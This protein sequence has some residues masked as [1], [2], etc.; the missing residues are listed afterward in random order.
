M[1]RARRGIEN[2]RVTSDMNQTLKEPL[3]KIAKHAAPIPPTLPKREDRNGVTGWVLKRS[4]FHQRE[5]Q[6]QQG[7]K[8]ILPTADNQITQ[9]IQRVERPNTMKLFQKLSRSSRITRRTR[10]GFTLIEIMI[11]VLIIG[12]LLSI[13]I[14]NFISA[15]ES[16]RAKACI[17]S[18]S[19]INSA[20]IQCSLENKLAI[21]STATFSLD[22]AT[23]TTLGPNG[24]YQL[25]TYGGNSNYMRGI[26]RCPSGGV[27]SSGTV[28]TPPTCN[29]A[30]ITGSTDYQVG[31]KWYHGY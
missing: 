31:G 17:Y 19:Q 22:G 25:I 6:G 15:R 10:R 27:Y 1:K 13:A 12:I 2:L 7:L 30:S 3:T 24:N 26:P 9:S 23:A 14:P 28:A 11:L 29:L 18:L 8:T 20:K 21:D 16:S 4:V 5:Y